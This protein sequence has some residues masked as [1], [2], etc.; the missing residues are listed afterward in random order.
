MCRELFQVNTPTAFQ[1]LIPF[2][3]A[4]SLAACLRSS[5]YGAVSRKLSLPFSISKVS[6]P[7]SSSSICRQHSGYFAANADSRFM[8]SV[9]WVCT[10]IMLPYSSKKMAVVFS[11]L[12]SPVLIKPPV[13]HYFFSALELEKW[14]DF[15]IET[16]QMMRSMF[17]L[18]LSADLPLFR[19]LTM[20]L[21]F[22]VCTTF[23][24]FHKLIFHHQFTPADPQG[25]KI[26][27]VQKVVC[28]RFGNLQRFRNLLCVHHIGHGF[29]W[30]SA[31]KILLSCMKKQQSPLG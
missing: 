16:L 24:P 15:S 1:P 6:P 28:P 25:W 31:H 4:H 12:V 22:P 7:C 30:F 19:L 17:R 11:L 10:S 2:F 18:T 5:L 14:C 9:L 13:F 3:F 26:R 21:H 8:R 29:K 20:F 27:A 23:Q